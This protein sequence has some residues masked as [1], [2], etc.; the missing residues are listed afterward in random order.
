MFKF[1]RTLYVNRQ[2]IQFAHIHV[3]FVVRLLKDTDDV[4]AIS[5]Y[6]V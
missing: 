5:E 4:Y 2:I 6:D 3:E 1:G